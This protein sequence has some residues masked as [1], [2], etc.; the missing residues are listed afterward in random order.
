MTH[1]CV[2]RRITIYRYP[3]AV[4]YDMGP[5]KAGLLGRRDEGDSRN[6]RLDCA[7][8]IKFRTAVLSAGHTRK[9]KWNEERA[10][11]QEFPR[12]TAVR[13]TPLWCLSPYASSSTCASIVPR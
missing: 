13:Q 7:P 1:G 2:L 8:R 10:L 12:S 6:C 4:A 3:L 5:K 9:A 11:G